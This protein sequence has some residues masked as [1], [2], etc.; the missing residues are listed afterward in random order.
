MSG[1][2]RCNPVTSEPC[3]TAAAFEVGVVVT[4]ARVGEAVTTAGLT[5]DR[6]VEADGP[7]VAIAS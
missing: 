2:T 1:L 5:P 3:D 7:A 4:T 6:V